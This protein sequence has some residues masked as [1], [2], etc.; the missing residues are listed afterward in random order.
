MVT[1]MHTEPRASDCGRSL[2]VVADTD[3]ETRQL[4]EDILDRAQLLQ[5]F[6]LHEEYVQPAEAPAE[7]SAVAQTS[8]A[9]AGTGEDVEYYIVVRKELQRIEEVLQQLPSAIKSGEDLNLQAATP[10]QLDDEDLGRLLNVPEDFAAGAR[11]AGLP[12][13]L[14]AI[15]IF[16]HP[17]LCSR[18]RAFLEA[19]GSEE[20][21][22]ASDN[23]G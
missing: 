7:V 16:T 4:E 17:A 10:L 13:E 14:A 12:E 9:P 23:E 5:R 22:G 8:E 21:D 20:P 11:G 19:I 2:V 3:D 6:S 1:A 18:L 15:D